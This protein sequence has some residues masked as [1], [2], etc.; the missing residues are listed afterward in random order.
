MDCLCWVETAGVCRWSS[1]REVH[2]F[3]FEAV[4]LLLCTMYGNGSLM[5]TDGQRVGCNDNGRH[6]RIKGRN[7]T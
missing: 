7:V 6:R 5:N 3:G 1:C 2:L 4:G